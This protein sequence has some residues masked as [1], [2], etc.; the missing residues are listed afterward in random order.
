MD[1]RMGC[2]THY[3]TEKL[4]SGKIINQKWFYTEQ[5]FDENVLKTRTQKIEHNLYFQSLIKIYRN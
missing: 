4:D 5:Q 1:K 3:V 2:T